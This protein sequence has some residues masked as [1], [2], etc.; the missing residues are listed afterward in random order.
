MTSQNNDLPSQGR[1]RVSWIDKTGLHTSWFKNEIPAEELYIEKRIV[2]IPVYFAKKIS[3]VL[4]AHMFD[5][6]TTA[7]QFGNALLQVHDAQWG[8]S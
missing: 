3:D 6:I 4:S 2:G 7:N 5:N 1:Y 8:R